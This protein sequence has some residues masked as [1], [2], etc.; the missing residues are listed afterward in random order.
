MKN[1]KLTAEVGQEYKYVAVSPEGYVY[2]FG[3]DME[4]ARKMAE[5]NW[6]EKWGGDAEPMPEFDV[7]EDDEDDEYDI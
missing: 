1:S 6:K 5:N 4:T 7:K 3:D 2:G